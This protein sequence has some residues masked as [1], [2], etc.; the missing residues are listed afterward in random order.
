MLQV[1]ALCRR[2]VPWFSRD[3]YMCVVPYL[4]VASRSGVMTI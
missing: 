1:S 3:A 4:E 2:A